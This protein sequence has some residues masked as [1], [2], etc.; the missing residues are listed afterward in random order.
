MSQRYA[1]AFVGEN[2]NGILRWWTQKIM[3]S[4]SRFGLANHLIDLQESAWP[5]QLA[6]TLQRGAPEFC[7]S[8]QGM[9]MNLLLENGQNIWNHH[10]IPFI[11]YL[12]DSPYHVP[13]LHAA[14]GPGMYFIY[15]TPDF[16]ETYTDYL[17]GRAFATTLQYG[18]PANSFRDLIPWKKRK[19]KALY[20]KTGVDS[21]ALRSEWDWTPRTFRTV[22]DDC[23]SSV[24]SGRDETLANLCDEVFK[25]RAIHVGNQRELFLFTC[26]VVDRYVRAVRAER[27]VNALMAHEE[28]TIIGDWSHLDQSGSRAHFLP[29]VSA[30]ELDELYTNTKV[31]I[32]SSPPVR[33]GIHERIVA[34]LFA[35]ASV[36]SDATPYSR[37]ILAGCP[38][39]FGVDI[40][41]D[42]FRDSIDTA[43][44]DCLSDSA[45]QDKIDA[46]AL[47]ADRLFSIEQ[48]A[49]EIFGLAE[50]ET[51]RRNVSSWSFQPVLT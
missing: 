3:D 31:V 34:G 19:C 11:S 37:K 22:L 45:M 7:F 38:S 36:I 15:G 10:K 25:D 4:L 49:Q 18:Y 28:V 8:F 14:Q 9:G 6:A 44:A 26:S 16:L 2:A 12:G 40:E 27:M 17:G 35:K 51:A 5:Q 13:R 48:F 50:I 43:L 21:R 24:L 39:F 46:S 47:V 30:T 20:V 42:S 1:L 33:S 32:N 41:S 23:A 29:P